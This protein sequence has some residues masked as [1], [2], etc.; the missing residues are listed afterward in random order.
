[1][2]FWQH[3]NSNATYEHERTDR[4]INLLTDVLSLQAIEFR[5]PG[6]P[7]RTSVFGGASAGGR[8]KAWKPI[9]KSNLRK[10]RVNLC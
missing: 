3:R 8:R 9:K 1:M 5:K 2:R 7:G 10:R 6:A 4:V